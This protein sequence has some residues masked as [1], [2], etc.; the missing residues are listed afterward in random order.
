VDGRSLAPLLGG[1]PPSEQDWRSA[2][3]VEAATEILGPTAVPPLSGDPLPEDWRHAPREEW[4]RPG[5]EAVRTGDHLYVEYGTGERELYDLRKDPYQLDNLY[6][7]ADPDL[8][9]R[10]KERIAVLRG[11]SGTECHEAEDGPRTGGTNR[12]MPGAPQ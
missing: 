1:D 5:L 3:L 11:C 7:S 12:K 6:E 9:K 2:F 8:L 10:L 4:G